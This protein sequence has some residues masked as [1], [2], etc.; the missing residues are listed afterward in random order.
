MSAL[1]L[2]DLL[3]S[4]GHRFDFFQLVE[5][6][7]EGRGDAT[8]TD[9]SAIRFRSDPSVAF[10][11]ADVSCV[12]KRG[13]GLDIC[14]AFMG[15]AGSSSPLPGY[16]VHHMAKY[17]GDDEALGDF[18]AIFNHR[19]YALLYEA[20]QR[21]KMTGRR[22]E[23]RKGLARGLEILTGA[24]RSSVSGP[25]RLGLACAGILARGARSA[26]GLRCLLSHYL[27]GPTVRVEEMVPQRSCV[28]DR[29]RLGRNTRLGDNALVGD[30]IPTL[31]GRFRVVV[32]PLGR[33][34]FERFTNDK[35]YARR[36]KQ[37]IAEYVSD[38]LDFEV[39]ISLSAP[40]LVPCRIGDSMSRI[41]RTAQLG[42]RAKHDRSAVVAI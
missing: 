31:A 20:W 38:P 4:S 37:V 25:A 1:D 18:L 39:H 21:S 26:A 22:D 29:P 5:L 17:E 16:F 13:N 27:G 33:T 36:L 32:G 15:L 19:I 2:E 28:P 34:G 40:E 7:R 10:P 41:G 42:S 11:A 3:C 23:R 8:S 14:L 24:D 12:R 30:T 35:E 6:L 9:G